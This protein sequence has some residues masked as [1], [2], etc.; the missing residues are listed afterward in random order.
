MCFRHLLGVFWRGVPPKTDRVSVGNKE[1][2]GWSNKRNKYR[3]HS[4]QNY[5]FLLDKVWI[6]LLIYVKSGICVKN[7]QKFG[8]LKEN[9]SI[10]DN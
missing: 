1:R 3:G 6:L 7:Y 4:D 10:S 8:S 9:W 5:V 2:K